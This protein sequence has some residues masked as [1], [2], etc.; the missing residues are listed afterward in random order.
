MMVSY[1]F[2]CVTYTNVVLNIEKLTNSIY[3]VRQDLNGGNEEM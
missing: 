3:F 2:P 1:N